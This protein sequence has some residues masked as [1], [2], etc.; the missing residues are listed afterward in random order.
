MTVRSARCNDKDRWLKFKSEE[1]LCSNYKNITNMLTVEHNSVSGTSNICRL[2]KS[3]YLC[4]LW[5]LISGTDKKLGGIFCAWIDGF[6]NY[7]RL[8]FH[9]RQCLNIRSVQPTRFK[10]SQFIYFCKTLYMFQAVF[11]SII[12]SSKLHIQ[13]QVL[14]WQIPDAVCAVL[15]FW[16]WTEKNRLK[17]VERLREINKLWNVA[18]CWLYSANILAMHGPMSVK[19]WCLNSFYLTGNTV[20]LRYKVTPVKFVDGTMRF[21][22]HCKSYVIY[23]CTTVWRV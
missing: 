22:R 23:C 20:R 13:R 2:N 21:H 4:T 1:D 14:V 19:K 9:L 12:R 6:M 18:S 17:H 3:C 10:V 5:Q 16:W 15:S 11:P 7:R 8:K